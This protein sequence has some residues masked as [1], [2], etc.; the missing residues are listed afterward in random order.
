MLRYFRINDPYRLLGLLL[1]LIIIYLP[2]F[3]DPTGITLPE[4]KSLLVGENV[5]QGKQLYSEI[6]DNTAPFSAWVHGFVDILFGRSL[7]AR[8]ILA[9]LIIFFHSAFIGIVFITRKGFNENT[10]IPSF[11]FS[12]LY[13]FSFDNLALSDELLGSGF[14]L[15]ALNN[16]FKEMEFRTSRDE[17]VL[18]LGIFVAIASLFYFPFMIFLFGVLVILFLFARTTPRKIALFIF[19]FMLPHLVMITIAYMNDSASAMWRNF[20]LSNLEFGG[21]ML[22][23]VKGILIVATFP[24]LY[25]TISMVMLN[26]LA[27]FSKYQSQLLQTVFL[28]IGFC[29]IF[30]LFCPQLRPQSFVVL[31]PPLS[32]LFTHFLLLIRRRRFAEMNTWILLIGIVSFAY[33]AR[34]DKLRGVSYDRLMV[35]NSTSPLKN[36]SV[37][38]L[39]NDPSVYLANRTAS[40]FINWDLAE[41]IFKSPEY[42]ESVVAVNDGLRSDP[43]QVIID[44]ENLLKPFLERLPELKGQYRKDG[45]I[46]KKISN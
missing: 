38:V 6:T 2:L 4:L 15:L 33:I 17:T 44:R 36:T 28:W 26:R 46:Y 10:F 30:F 9:F 43:P 3:L 7:L 31:I 13:F 41:E 18:N 42:Y 45:D 29:F 12:I 20:Y 25:F 16:V 35:Q 23:S 34:Y 5:H 39:G 14:L 22:M 40:A 32:F 19:G 37:L 8:H 1:L 24:I 11:I 21:E 27:R